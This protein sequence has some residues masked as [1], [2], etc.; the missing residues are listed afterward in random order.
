MRSRTRVQCTARTRRSTRALRVGPRA[1]G[2]RDTCAYGGWAV[3]LIAVA[4][5]ATM[6]L[7]CRAG[8]AGARGAAHAGHA[9][10]APRPGP[11]RGLGRRNALRLLERRR[12]R[13]PRRRA[14]G[15]STAVRHREWRVAVVLAGRRMDRVSGER[16]PAEDRRGRR[17]R[18]WRCCPADSLSAGRVS[19][20]EDG[21]IVF[22]TGSRPRRAS[23]VRRASRA[24]EGHRSGAAAD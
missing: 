5:A 19:W 11:L 3:A 9:E 16:R 22:E 15:V 2:G 12:D 23:E 21:S 13:V 14:A 17:S 4:A 20:G 18:R 24:Q 8:R 10:R 6:G 1:R 7:R